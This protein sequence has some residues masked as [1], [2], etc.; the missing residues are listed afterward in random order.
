VLARPG[1]RGYEVAVHLSDAVVTAILSEPSTLR[2]KELADNYEAGRQIAPLLVLLLVV[3]AV[4]IVGLTLLVLKV[5]RR[6]AE[7]LKIAAE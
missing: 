6:R 7:M 2:Q 1:D 5:R 3:V 4:G